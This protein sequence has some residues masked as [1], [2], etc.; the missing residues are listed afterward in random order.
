MREQN[1]YA[2]FGAVHIFAGPFEI[3]NWNMHL[4]E[5]TGRVEKLEHKSM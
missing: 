2:L 3:E 4:I 5:T 1:S